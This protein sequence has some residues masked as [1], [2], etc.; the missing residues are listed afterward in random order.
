MLPRSHRIATKHF[1]R[2]TQGK[3][4]TNDLFRVV[5][6]MDDTLINPRCAVIVSKKLA[7]TAVARNRMR[8]QVYAALVPLIPHLPKAFIT[9]F[10]KTS[11]A[12]FQTLAENLKSLLY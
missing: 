6:R 8:R 10:P 9:V 7:K 4:K 12:D 5:V 2:V 1:P 3:T 11:Q